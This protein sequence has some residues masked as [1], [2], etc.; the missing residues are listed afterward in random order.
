[1]LAELRDHPERST[2]ESK[3]GRLR[4]SWKEGEVR[5]GGFLEDYA[6]LIEGLLALYQ[7]TFNERWFVAAR[8]LADTMLGHFANPSGGFYDTSDEAE[9]LVTRPQDLQDNATPSGNAMAA[10]VLLKLGAYTGEGRYTE[11]AE[12]GLSVVQKALAAAPAGFAQWLSALDFARGQPREIAIV[13]SG[14]EARRLVEEVFRE[15]RP[16]QVVAL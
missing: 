4:R 11:Q 10:T 3:G 15:Y 8:E 13:G 5:V 14:E 16:N 7:T 6:H 9:Q 1:M 12:R 2:V